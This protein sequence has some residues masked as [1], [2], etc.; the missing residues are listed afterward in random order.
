MKKFA[1][2]LSDRMRYRMCHL[3]SIVGI[4]SLPYITHAQQ[5]DIWV[6]GN[7][8]GIDFNSGVP[9]LITTGLSF[10]EGCAAISD[11]EGHLLFATDGTQVWDRDFM[12]MPNGFSLAAGLSTGSTSQGAIIVP[13]LDS[14]HKYYIFSLTC[15]EMGIDRGRLYYSVVNMN[16]NGG[17]GD[18]E[19][20]TKS[21]L[22]DSMLT[23]Q[24]TAVVGD[25]CNIWLVA[26]SRVQQAFKSFEITGSGVNHVPQ[27]SNPGG[28]FNSYM[29]EVGRM[30]VSA[31]RKKLSIGRT[32]FTGGGY[33]ELYDF[34]PL[35]GFVTNPL[36][37]DSAHGYYGLAFSPDNTKL[38]ANRLTDPNVFH[39]IVQ[40]NLVSGIPATIINS[41]VILGPAWADIKLGPDGK[42]Y[43]FSWAPDT[44]LNR[45]NYPNLAGNLCQYQ[46]NVLPLLP[47]TNTSLGFPQIIPVLERDTLFS[48]QTDSM[49][50][51]S[52]AAIFSALDTGGWGYLWHDGSVGVQHQVQTNGTYWVRYY[53]S[54]CIYHVDT[55]QVW[56]P[57]GLLPVVQ[58]SPSCKVDA[59][60]IAWIYTWPDDA[61]AYTYVWKYESDTVVLSNTD[62]LVHVR[63]GHYQ[64]QITT[65]TGCD[66]TLFFY[67]PEVEYT[68]SFITDSISCEGDTLRFENTSEQH[69]DTWYWTFGDNDSATQGSPTHTYTQPGSYEVMLVARGAI[70]SDTTY[71]TIIVDAPI[72][73]WEFTTDRDSIC[74]GMAIVLHPQMDA[75]VNTLD[76]HFGDGSYVQQVLPEPL[77]HAYDR[78]G[79]FPITVSIY[80]RACPDASFTDTVQ[81]Y[82]L[83]EVDLGA[84][85]SL[86]LDG[87]AV[88]LRNLAVAPGV[89]YHYLWNTGDTTAGLRVLQPGRYSLR[90]TTEPLGCN[91]TDEIEVTKD[92]YTD[93]PNAFTP[94]GDGDNDYFFPRTLLSKSVSDFKMQV[95]NRWGLV[96]FETTNIDGHGWDGRFNDKEQPL[97]VYIYLIEVTYINGRKEAYRGN[98]TLIR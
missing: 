7:G 40:F 69:F 41:Q 28:A 63:S 81:V 50:C 88:V 75:T 67:I 46:L 34:D 97:G 62:S 78:V 82:A 60:G 84:D 32:S 30:A 57:T 80:S 22:L 20:G 8:A 4:M 13:V 14:A 61:T 26:A 42:I 83:P 89:P 43:T 73:N 86:C 94:N 35:S 24:L 15:I 9:T 87:H 54:P 96:V 18:V 49:P 6:F 11:N 56:F 58:S 65:P 85:T 38:Y 33:L 55:F 10:F 53:T 66:T 29:H 36:V 52:P 39:T 64:I 27:I 72:I 5:E 44:A 12:Q 16:L 59:N 37:L 51:F 23:E 76:W 31:N 3:L 70:C 98:V 74:T 1:A 77:Q 68:A 2:V 45:V 93:I 19:P 92:C 21:I 71:K 25:G 17:M 79:R 48:S 91:T 47:E 95:F 90:I